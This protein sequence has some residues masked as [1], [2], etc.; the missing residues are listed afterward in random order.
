MNLEKKT[1][2]SALNEGY[3]IKP[4]CL[5]DFGFLKSKISKPFLKTYKIFRS[6]ISDSYFA[7]FTFFSLHLFFFCFSVNIKFFESILFQPEENMKRIVKRQSAVRKHAGS[8]KIFELT[9]IDW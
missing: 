3:P 9:T 8:K 5:I 4:P 2:I 6:F 1:I 7:V